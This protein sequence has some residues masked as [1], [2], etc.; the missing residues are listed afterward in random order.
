MIRYSRFPVPHALLVDVAETM[1]RYGRLRL[2]KHPVHG[3]VLRSTDRAVL[4]LVTNTV[5]ARQWR[6]ELLER[7]LT[8]D[9][10]GEYSGA[11]KEVRPVTI[12]TY[13]SPRS[14]RAPTPTWT[15]STPATGA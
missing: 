11:R 8:E 4:I 10:I 2:L 6:D 5:S 13:Q 1:D 15:C 14:G 9:E 7:E 12:A 3:L